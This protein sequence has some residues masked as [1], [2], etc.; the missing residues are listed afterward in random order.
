MC[1][2]H[3]NSTYQYTYSGECYTTCPPGTYVDFTN[4]NCLAC[5][6]LCLTCEGNSMNCTGCDGTFKFSTSCVS[7]CPAGYYGLSN[8]C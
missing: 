5:N 1:Y 7:Q 8:S 2:A 3:C 4:V 6:A